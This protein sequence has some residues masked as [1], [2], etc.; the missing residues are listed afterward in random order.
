MDGKKVIREQLTE[1]RSMLGATLDDLKAALETCDPM[2]PTVS[3]AGKVEGID[4]PVAREAARAIDSALRKLKP[5]GGGPVNVDLAAGH[6]ALGRQSV[7]QD[8][9]SVAL[10]GA[11]LVKDLTKF[12]RSVTADITAL[13]R[14]VDGGQLTRTDATEA[15]QALRNLKRALADLNRLNF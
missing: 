11:L 10:S 4:D 8:G 3:G 2:T 1:Y 12:K 14:A 7:D 6:D 9:H 5:V 13:Q 15:R